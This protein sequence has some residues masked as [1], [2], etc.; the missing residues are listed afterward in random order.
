MICFIENENHLQ[1]IAERQRAILRT[2][3]LKTGIETSFKKLFDIMIYDARAKGKEIW[4][5]IN[6]CDYIYLDTNFYGESSYMMEDMCEMALKNKIINKTIINHRDSDSHSNLSY[7]GK[8]ML[9]I[10]K[11]RNNIKYIAKDTPEY[12]EILLKILQ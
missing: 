9:E 3:H 4:E 10:L 2:I 5:A 11:V 8:R 6:K 7:R 12:K 1:L